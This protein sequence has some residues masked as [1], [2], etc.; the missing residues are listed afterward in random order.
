MAVLHR[1]PPRGFEALRSASEL[2]FLAKCVRVSP[3]PARGAD[4]LT[5]SL[6][7][8]SAIVVKPIDMVQVNEGDRNVFSL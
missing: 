8:S 2:V 4:P 7:M 3:L 6:G 5:T 1:L